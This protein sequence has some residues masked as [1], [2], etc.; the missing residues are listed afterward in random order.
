MR[1]LTL[2]L[3]VRAPGP[4]RIIGA[5]LL[6]RLF[7]SG[8]FA[9]K[10]PAPPPTSEPTSWPKAHKPARG[11]TTETLIRA[12]IERKIETA[13]IHRTHLLFPGRLNRSD[14]SLVCERWANR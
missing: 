11:K 14:C 13:R 1:S 4:R 3:G 2:P 12:K 7:A 6:V 5:G 9:L 8:F 10:I